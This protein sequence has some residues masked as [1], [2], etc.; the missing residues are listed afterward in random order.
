M[1]T[2]T[3]FAPELNKTYHVHVEGID[4]CM[5]GTVIATTKE[6]VVLANEKGQE[7]AFPIDVITSHREIKLRSAEEKA[8][9][10]DKVAA[11][12]T[13][14]PNAPVELLTMAMR[15][16]DDLPGAAVEIHDIEM[17]VSRSTVHH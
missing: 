3:K 14:F 7:Q 1:T 10:A 4:K 8:A 11:L 2:T 12:K 15:F 9:E 17:M 16:V 6:W 5:E 13:L